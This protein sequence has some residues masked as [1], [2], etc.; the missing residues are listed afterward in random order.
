[1]FKT[2]KSLK[3]YKTHGRSFLY[4]H[5]VHVIKRKHIRKLRYLQILISNTNLA[6]SKSLTPSLHWKSII[7]L[8]SV[9]IRYKSIPSSFNK[10][11]LLIDTGLLNQASERKWARCHFSHYQNG[12]IF[13]YI[14]NINQFVFN[15]EFRLEIEYRSLSTYVHARRYCRILV[16]AFRENCWIVK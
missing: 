13:I 7:K 12:M 9:K 16:N 14:F 5:K 10:Y 15:K 1:M 2:V 8:S 4:I 11:K 6:C 3:L